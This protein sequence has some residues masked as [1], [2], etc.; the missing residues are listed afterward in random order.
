[1]I[2]ITIDKTSERPLKVLFWFLLSEIEARSKIGEGAGLVNMPDEQE[3][4]KMTEQIHSVLQSLKLAV[5]IRD[6]C[7]RE[8][9][10]SPLQPLK[11]FTA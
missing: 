11:Q 2:Y 1:M 4:R 9:I 3:I 7:G 8:Q 5:S 6:I 10:H